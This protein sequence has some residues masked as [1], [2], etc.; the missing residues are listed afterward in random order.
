MTAIF[1]SK[2]SSTG[3]TE[4]SWDKWSQSMK[5]MCI[6]QSSVVR[7]NCSKLQTLFWGRATTWGF[8]SPELL[9][10]ISYNQLLLMAPHTDRPQAHAGAYGLRESLPYG[11]AVRVPPSAHQELLKAPKVPRMVPC[12][13]HSQ[14]PRWARGIQLTVAAAGPRA[15][16]LCSRATATAD[17]WCCKWDWSEA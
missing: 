14:A 4:E 6:H 10:V 3:Y 13:H 12:I 2:V 7:W 9:F 8:N 15:G 1:L 5:L 17:G 11:R 16:P